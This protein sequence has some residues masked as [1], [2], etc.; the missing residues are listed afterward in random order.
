LRLGSDAGS[1]PSHI[2]AGD[3]LSAANDVAQEGARL[4]VIGSLATG[5]L[6][7]GPD[8]TP[9]PIPE[10][11]RRAL[12]GNPSS[13]PAAKA[14]RKAGEGEPCPSCR[15]TM[16]TGTKNFPTA[17]HTP[18]L[19]EHYFKRGHKMTP[20]ERKAYAKS[21]GSMSGAVCKVCQSKQGAAEARKVYD[22]K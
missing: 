19:K 20:A 12:Y 2:Q 22:H 1:L 10:Y 6:R 5:A 7:S 17:E 15:T 4:V 16:R 14:K 9:E 21:P 8:V 3:Y 13:S 18:T 11:N